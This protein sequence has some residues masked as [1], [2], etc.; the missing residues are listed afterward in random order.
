MQLD[1]KRLIYKRSSAVRILLCL[2][3]SIL[4]VLFDPIEVKSQEK[5]LTV[6]IKVLSPCV[7]EAEGRYTGFDAE[8]WEQIAKD[9]KLEFNYRLTDQWRIFSGLVE[10]KADIAFSCI[11]ITHE[12]EETV[13][14]SHHYLES[15][16]RILVL[17]KSTFSIKNALKSISH[18]LS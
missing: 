15:G 11:P 4:L 1:R 3:I 17:N 2:F 16:L 18:P 9:L 12:L 13:D 8:L 14:F 5:P 10:G 7:M 6:A